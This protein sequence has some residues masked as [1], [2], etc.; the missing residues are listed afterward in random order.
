MFNTYNANPVTNNNINAVSGSL[1]KTF[2]ESRF[3]CCKIGG[4][5][6]EGLFPDQLDVKPYLVKNY[7][8]DRV[9]I[10]I[11]QTM[12][13][14]NNIIMVEFITKKDYDKMFKVE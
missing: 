14:G 12:L 2:R 11:L 13:M 4:N 7:Y 6:F 9:E 3:T 10:V 1:T 5:V 8:A